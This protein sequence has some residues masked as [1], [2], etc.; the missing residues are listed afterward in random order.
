MIADDRDTVA[1]FDAVCA[2][3]GDPKGAANWIMGDIAAHLKNTGAG[4]GGI[5]ALALRPAGL[6]ELLALIA[7]GTISGKIGKEILPELL[8][9]G[10]SPRELVQA[11]GLLQISDTAEIEAIIDGVI[12]ENAKQV[13]EFRAGRDKVKGFFVGQIMKRSG[14]RVNPALVDQ[15][16][17]PKLRGD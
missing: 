14:G 4:A 16:L 2:A 15:L 3:G 11:R 1:Y 9:A 10:G 6:A 8:A 7:D 17:L 13:A 5:A 12:S